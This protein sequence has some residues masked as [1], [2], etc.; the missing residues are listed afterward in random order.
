[1][2][3]EL[4]KGWQGCAA[5]GYWVRCGALV[6]VGSFL[7]IG[8]APRHTPINHSIG[9]H[10]KFYMDSHATSSSTLETLYSQ[11]IRPVLAG[12][13]EAFVVVNILQQFGAD[14]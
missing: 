13:L 11:M 5:C 7:S 2:P 3:G 1:M 8:G 14:W 4:G 10:C 6:I 12:L 9:P